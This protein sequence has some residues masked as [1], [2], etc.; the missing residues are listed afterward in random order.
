MSISPGKLPFVI[1][2]LQSKEILLVLTMHLVHPKVLDMMGSV[3]HMEHNGISYNGSQNIHLKYYINENKLIQL[4][5]YNNYV[6]LISAVT[7]MRQYLLIIECHWFYTTTSQ[8]KVTELARLF[9]FLTVV[10]YIM[11]TETYIKY[12]NAAFALIVVFVS[13]M[14]R[15]TMHL[16]ED[17]TWLQDKKYFNK[18]WVSM[19]YELRVDFYFAH[20][21]YRPFQ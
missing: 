2:R 3:C 12:Y 8:L 7:N 21:H 15:H 1:C 4:Y 9:A 13:I 14:Y 10:L 16:F 17:V 11:P 20:L 18:S 5:Y 19:S 6:I